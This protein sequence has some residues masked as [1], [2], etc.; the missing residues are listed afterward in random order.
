MPKIAV[1]SDI[2]SN[3]IALQKCLDYALNGGIDTFVFLGDYLGELAYPQKTMAL[4]YSMKDRYRCFFIRGNK[5]DYWLNHRKDSTGW[6]EYSSTT[7]CL[8]YT[9]QNLSEEDLRFFQSLPITDELSFDGLPPVTICHGSPR[10]VK[11]K[12]L[13]DDKNTFQIL[14]NHPNNYILCGHTHVQGKIAHQ[15]K[16]A[17]NPGSVGVPLESGGKT[18]FLILTDLTERWDYEFVSLD[19]DIERVIEELRL[20]GLNEKAP[21]WCKVSETALR[22]GQ[23]SHMTV[24]MR[25]MEL[26]K[27]RFGVCSWP[28]IPEECWEQAVR[29]LLP[30]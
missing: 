2:H 13:P 29:E 22:T 26:C 9:C 23:V 17:L 16:L 15:G 12:L 5:E 7:G 4:L 1:L 20:S 8:Y 6:R 25:A 24:L 10:N 3:Y 14:E 28:D 21:Y 27:E 11:E 18:Q 19:Y 30:E